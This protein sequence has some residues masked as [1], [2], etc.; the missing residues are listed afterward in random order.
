LPPLCFIV[1][2][3]RS[4][5]SIFSLN[6]SNLIWSGNFNCMKAFVLSESE[7]YWSGFLL[8]RDCDSD[9]VRAFFP[10]TITEKK[11][12]ADTTVEAREKCKTIVASNEKDFIRCIR[13]AQKREIGPRCEDCWGLVVLPN[14]DLQRKNAL[15]KANIKNGLKFGRRM[16]PWK[17]VGYHRKKRPAVCQ[18]QRHTISAQQSRKALAH[19]E[20]N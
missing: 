10:G 9:I 7:N 16:M 1:W 13:E 2:S 12:D 15:E 11:D 19:A 14:K 5:R 6:V 17:A 18:P 8:E 3:N 4:R 20:A